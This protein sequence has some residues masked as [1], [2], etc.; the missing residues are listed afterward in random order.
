[1]IAPM[2]SG[3]TDEVFTPPYA[4]NPLIPY[5]KKDW[6]IF[7]CAYGEGNL[8]NALR[9]YEFSVFGNCDYDF[10]G[11]TTE[12]C[13]IFD[14]I[15]TNPPFS[16]KTKFL[17]KCFDIGKPF[18]LLLPL[19]ALEGKER[20]LL[21][22]ENEIQLIIPDKRIHFIMTAPHKSQKS[23]AWFQ[24]AWFTH[25]LNLPRQLTFVKAGW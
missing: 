19:T 8:A 10:L 7:E 21:Y 4:I 12:W 5:L 23:S 24:T 14:C 18:A 15:I 20:N 17:K 2:S 22:R 1:M 25:G 6:L 16:K 9:S 3:K 13:K 11:D